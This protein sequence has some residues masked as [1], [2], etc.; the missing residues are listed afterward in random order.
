MSDTEK[1]T[2]ELLTAHEHEGQKLQPP[3]TIDVHPDTANFL[4][5]LGIAKKA[6]RDVKKVLG[7]S[8]SKPD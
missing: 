3:S 7:G 5:S 1:V 8:K 6:T 2:L 4:L